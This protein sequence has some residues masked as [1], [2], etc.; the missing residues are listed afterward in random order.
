MLPETPL[1]ERIHSRIL[2]SAVGPHG[3]L[4]LP[5]LIRLFQ[6]AAM[7]NTQRLR[8]STPDLMERHGLTWVLH[9]QLVTA[10]AWPRLGDA[11]TV[12]TAPTRVDR[13]LVTIREFEL[14]DA[15][16]T[17]LIASSSAWSVMDFA[18]R[19]IRPLPEEVLRLLPDLPP[20]AGTPW[21][22]A[23]LTVPDHADHHRE[24]RVAFSHLDF[25]NH[26]TNPSFAE[27]MVEPLG[28]DYLST[29]LPRRA[30]ITYHREARYADAL[31]AAATGTDGTVRHTLRRAD[32][33]LALMESEWTAL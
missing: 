25:N 2:A 8:I 15:S 7:Q 4:T 14:L 1:L 3:R 19:R 32:D 20:P 23:K 22:G 12:I 27:L 18:A 29:H 11:V 28:L 16:G 9:R 5:H 33:L 6:E 10:T 26:L 31:V 30:D 24:F 17:L 13:R 21:P